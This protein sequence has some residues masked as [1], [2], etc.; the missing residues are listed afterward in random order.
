MYHRSIPKSK[1][2]VTISVTL[3]NK[4]Y[5][6]AQKEQLSVGKYIDQI[7]SA[8]LPIYKDRPVVFFNDNHYTDMENKIRFEQR[9]SDINKRQIEA[10]ATKNY[11]DKSSVFQIIMANYFSSQ[12]K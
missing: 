5:A 1:L 4:I 9:I 10:L 2:S 7:L 11:T 12:G 3:N 6:D 8:I